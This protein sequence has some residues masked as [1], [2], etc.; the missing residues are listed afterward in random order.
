MEKKNTANILKNR[1]DGSVNLVDLFFYLLSYWYWFVLGV[2]V[3]AGYA[4]YKY[5]TSNFEYVSN[6]TIIIKNPS[7][8]RMSTRLDAYSNLINRTNV[9]NEILQFRSKRL[10]TEVVRRLDANVN[11]EYEVKLRRVELYGN[12]PV[13]AIF[14]P[15]L[16]N[17]PMSFVV[18]PLDSA[19]IR[20]QMGGNARTLNLNDT[21]HVSGGTVIFAPTSNFSSQEFV[22]KPI[23]VSKNDAVQT[24]KSFIARLSI[25]QL[26]DDASI[27]T[28]SMR[29]RNVNR[30]SDIL[31]TLFDVYNEDAINDKNQVVINTAKFISERIVII[32]EELNEV[33]GEL[34]QFKS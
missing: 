10:M 23:Y 30:A 5:A 7:N 27:L 8:T 4:G 12:T 22:G 18:E 26:N 6:A 29:D 3:C 17:V 31:N 24:A 21:L 14:S 32:G 19:S 9:S 2:L 16:E 34:Q 20:V 25:R 1:T 33:E 11:Y 28:F 13:K 15:E